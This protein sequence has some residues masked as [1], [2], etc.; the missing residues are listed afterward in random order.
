MMK[1]QIILAGAALA[2][3]A[4]ADEWTGAEFIS[5]A[6]VLNTEAGDATSAFLK[7]VVNEKEVFSATLRSTALGV[8]EAYVNGAETE[9]FLKPGFTHVYKRRLETKADVT[10]LWKREA[11]ATNVLSALVTQGWWRDQ[12]TG[13]RGRDTGFRAILDLV[14]ADGSKR[15]V[16]TDGNWL[17]GN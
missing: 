12:I 1:L 5:V 4:F 2:A 3:S 9:G 14:Y 11:G 16:V 15:Q 17:S 7:C 10:R 6:K 8:Y 13:K